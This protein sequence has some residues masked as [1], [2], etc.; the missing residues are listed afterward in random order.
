MNEIEYLYNFFTFL[1]TLLFSLYLF[2]NKTK[3]RSSNIYIGYFIFYMG[4]E[5]LDSL[6]VQSSFYLDNPNLYLL[7]PCLG[8]LLYPVIYYYIKT[9]AFKG[10]K[11]KWLDLIHFTPFL[12]IL[13]VLLFEY[14]LQSTEAKVEIM[15]NRGDMPWFI[16]MIYYVLRIQGLIYMIL[17][18]K[19]ILRFRAIVRENYSTKNKRDYKWLL[20]LTIVFVYYALS[21]LVFN[22]NRFGLHLLSNEVVFYISA[23]VSLIFLIW[24]IYK[25]LSQPYIFNGVDVNIKLL[26][27]YLAE[28]EESKELPMRAEDNTQNLAIKSK[29]E[30]YMDT[31]EVYQ[32]PSLTIF[33]LSKGIGLSSSELSHFLNKYMGKN[34]FE[35]T[36]EYRIERAKKMLK[37]TENRQL[38]ILEILYSVGF[39]SK[40]S[41]NTAFKKYVGKTPTE[42]RNEYVK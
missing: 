22:I 42:Y 12:V 25:A 31:H 28:R 34:F 4:L 1:L 19:I 29:L 35:F 2:F 3:E 27:E 40:S 16:S 33:E 14:Y 30:A 9:T 8:L 23:S 10:I 18:I 36:N 11:L 32:N 37:D 39:N 38:T 17:S 7:I 21:T 26:K 20:Q 15:T 41:F 6:L 13:A 5:S 24:I